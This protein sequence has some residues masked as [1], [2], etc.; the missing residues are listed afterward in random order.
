MEFSE[1]SI[2]AV[3]ERTRFILYKSS[4]VD[5]PVTFL[6]R[7]SFIL[8]LILL[9]LSRVRIAQLYAERDV[10]QTWH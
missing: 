3:T 10:A 9:V 6:P 5:S 2:Q 7:L 4:N 1:L 8:L